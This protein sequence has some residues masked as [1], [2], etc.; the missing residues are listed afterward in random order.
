M[1]QRT[2]DRLVRYLDPRDGKLNVSVAIALK[3]ADLLTCGGFVLYR[4][5]PIVV[6]GIRDRGRRMLPGK[7]RA[8][9]KWQT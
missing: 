8:I 1:T 3:V 6:S 4:D 7:L 5:S 2:A 9:R